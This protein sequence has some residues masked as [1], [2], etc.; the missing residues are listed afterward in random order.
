MDKNGI[1]AVVVV[2]VAIVLIGLWAMRSGSQ[3]AA[4]RMDCDAAPGAPSGLAH[5][6][7]GDLVT[8]NWTASTGTDPV[9]TYVVEA[10]NS[11]GV[12]NAGVFVVPGNM[13]MFERQA[14]PGT[15]YARVLAR[16]GCGTSSP[17]NEVVV[18]V[19]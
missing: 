1:I 5:Q 4:G 8:L 9:S 3:N 19:P 16:N 11:P 12:S 14:P 17:S 18:T 13:T 15:Y 10:G 2:V 7:K 6:K